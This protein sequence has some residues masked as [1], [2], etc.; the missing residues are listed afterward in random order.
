MEEEDIVSGAP[1]KRLKIC[2]KTSQNAVKTKEIQS[3]DN[4][5]TTDTADDGEGGKLGQDKSVNICIQSPS[6]A[7]LGSKS[8]AKV[9]ETNPSLK[10]EELIPMH[11]AEKDVGITEYVSKHEGFQGILKQRYVDF[12][13]NERDLSGNLVQLTNT[14]IPRESASSQEESEDILSEE[15]LE[16]VKSVLESKDIKFNAILS[17]DD[18]KDHRTKTHRY[19]KGKFPSLG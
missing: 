6:E 11:T 8:D 5:E 10:D 4:M 12:L 9:L 16:K 7:E 3:H 18:D 2:E 14:D 13:V 15:D 17:H 1:C 19:I